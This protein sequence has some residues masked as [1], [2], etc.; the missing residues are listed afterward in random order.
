MHSEFELHV[1]FP[2]YFKGIGK[3]LFIYKLNDFTQNSNI[4]VDT[5]TEQTYN[6]LYILSKGTHTIDLQ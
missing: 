3:D 4:T 2:T 1:Y 5:I 6:G